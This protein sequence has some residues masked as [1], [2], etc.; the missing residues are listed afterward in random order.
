MYVRVKRD[1]HEHSSP[2]LDPKMNYCVVSPI[3]LEKPLTIPMTLKT[4]I[5]ILEY[6][7]EN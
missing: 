7:K 2:C 1:Q 4:D 3:S 6:E 5:P